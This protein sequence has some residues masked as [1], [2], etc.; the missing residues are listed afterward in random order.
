MNGISANPLVLVAL[1]GFA[2]YLMASA[3]LRLRKLRNRVTYC[4]VCRRPREACT[5]RWL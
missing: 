4:P 2:A 5:C 3:G 1:A